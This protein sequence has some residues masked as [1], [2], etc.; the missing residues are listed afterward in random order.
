MSRTQEVWFYVGD[1]EQRLETLLR[2]AEAAEKDAGRSQR[3]L[4]DSPAY[5]QTIQ[6]F[7]ALREEAQRESRKVVLKAA[8]RKIVRDL[9][10]AHPPRTEGVA[11]EVKNL[12]LLYSMNVEAVQ[13]DL[14]FQ[15]LVDPTFETRAAFDEWALEELDEAEFAKLAMTA[16]GMI[17]SAPDPKSLRALN[18]PTPAETSS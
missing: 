14:V 6:D 18:I 8:N 1:Y 4:L 12:D 11:D 13:E 2:A 5:Q 10:K 15:T 17:V 3:R 9:R 7:N 16:L